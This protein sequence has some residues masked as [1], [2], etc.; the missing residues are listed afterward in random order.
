M[1]DA[2]GHKSAEARHSVIVLLHE[3]SSSWM[4]MLHH[5]EVTSLRNDCWRLG[6]HKR[7]GLNFITSWMPSKIYGINCV[8]AHNSHNVNDWMPCISRLVP[9]SINHSLTMMPSTVHM[10]SYWV[11]EI[12]STFGGFWDEEITITCS[13]FHDIISP[14]HCNLM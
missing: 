13:Y 12:P 7:S 6:Y 8:K 2:Q 11:T 9:L 3:I 10:T 4:R 5:F 14:K 1:I